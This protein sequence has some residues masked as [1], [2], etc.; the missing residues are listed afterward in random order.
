[1]KNKV[2]VW[3]QNDSKCFGCSPSWSHGWPGAVFP[4]VAHHQEDALYHV[5]LGQEKIKIQNMVSTECLP[6]S[7]CHKV[8]K[9]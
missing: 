8:E 5:F 6:L 2:V 7:H 4:A 9:S 3:V 1:M